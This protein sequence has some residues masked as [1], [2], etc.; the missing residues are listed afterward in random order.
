MR[1]VENVMGTAVSIE[2]TDLLPRRTLAELIDDTCA[3]LHEVDRRF[4]TYKDDSEVNQIERG[5]LAVDRCSTDM[6]TVLD[7][8]AALRR[9]TDGYFDDRAAGRFDPSGYVKGWS[10]EV[11]SARLAQAGSLNHC[12]NAGGDIRSRGCPEPGRSWRFGIR[13]PWE[14]DKLAWVLTGT[15]LAVATSGTYE[16]GLHVFDPHSGEPVRALRSVTVTGPNLALADAYATAAMAMG[17]KGLLWL[18]GLSASGYQS[19]AITRDGHAYTSDQ[20]PILKETPSPKDAA[21]TE[22]VPKPQAAART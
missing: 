15:D 14:H 8:C 7:A 1:H 3:W 5:E 11:A 19:A 9:E 13:H 12:I 21:S 17:S 20:L 22:G 18:A 2:I 10:V 6:R 16:R 4:S